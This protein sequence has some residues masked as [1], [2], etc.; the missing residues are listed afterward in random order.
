MLYISNE[1]IRDE[2]LSDEAIVAYAFLQILTYSPNYDSVTFNIAQLVDQTY[3]QVNSHSVYDK[4]KYAFREIVNNGYLDIRQESSHWWRIFMTS[5]KVADE[6]Y[7]QVSADDIR[8]IIDEE[9][10]RNKPSIVRYYLLLLSTIYSKTKVGIF[11]QEWFC[12]QMDLSKQTI[13]KYTMFLEE[14][15]LIYVYRSGK[16]HISNTYGRFEDKELIRIEGE[17]RSQGCEAHANANTKRKFLEGKEYD[18]DTLK[19]ILNVMRDRNN[20]LLNLGTNAR[21]EVYDLQPLIDK[22]NA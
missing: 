22:I 10:I 1:I 7:V 13:S 14:M 4:V 2:D 5:F 9:S 3:G 17:K 15:E 18:Q 8:T 19:E 21:G 12:K 6:G 11:D 16:N 20:E